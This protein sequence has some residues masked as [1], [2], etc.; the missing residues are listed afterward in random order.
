MKNW[1]TVVALGLGVGL[2]AQ[3]SSAAPLLRYSFDE[4]SGPALDTGTGT[5]DNGALMGGAVRSANTPSGAGSSIDFTTESTYAHVLGSDAA[6]L[7]GNNQLTLITWLNVS[8]YPSGNNRLV[9]KQSGGAFG[10][11]NFTMNA[12]PNDGT[13][14]ANNFRVGLF[15]GNNVSSGA[16]DFG[17]AFANAD[18]ENAGGNWAFLAVTYDGTLASNNTKFYIGDTTGSVT[19]LGATQSIV[20][21]TVDGGTARFGV[22]FTDAAPTS[23]TS[24][25]GLQDDVRVYNSVLDATALEA[26]RLENIPEP[27]SLAVLG[28]G[29]LGLAARRRR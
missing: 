16:A 27:G 22:G 20:P 25:I 5:P 17:S 4:A 15:V 21:L 1:A 12:A 28:L 10:G 7:D 19:Q 3:V 18:V 29:A 6:K 23:N 11:F 8:T 2:S 24:V 26:A 13:V 9:A 14:S